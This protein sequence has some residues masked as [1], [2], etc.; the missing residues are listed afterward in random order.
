MQEHE[1]SFKEM[2]NPP[3]T[4]AFDLNALLLTALAPVVKY[5]M[6]PLLARVD[7]LERSLV[8]ADK[9]A[10]GNES[11]LFSRMAL[12]EDKLDNINDASDQRIKEIAEEV[13]EQA[14]SDHN[15]L[16]DHDEYDRL[17]NDLGDKVDEAVTEA[18]DEIDFEDKVRDIMRHAS[19][20]IDI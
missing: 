19:V 18:V 7:V 13:A 5:M 9:A 17:F 15:H 8:V 4:P 2:L 16:Y 3:A 1:S 6:A 10:Q 14:I 12:L 20:S 11:D